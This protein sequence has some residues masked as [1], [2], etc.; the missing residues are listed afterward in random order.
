MIGG[1]EVLIG[2][3]ACYAVKQGLMS[4][5]A[6][7]RLK[8][9]A[10]LCTVLGICQLDNALLVTAAKI[11]IELRLFQTPRVLE[12]PMDNPGNRRYVDGLPRWTICA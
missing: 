12:Q 1:N 8:E 5:N 3:I 4:I 10:A 9:F 2:L 7:K 6:Q 11:Y